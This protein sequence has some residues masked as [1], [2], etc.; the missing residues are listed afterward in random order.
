M[1]IVIAVVLL[2]ILAALG[3]AGLFMLRKPKPGQVGRGN[4]MARA[5]ALRVGLSV[6]LFLFIL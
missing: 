3:S 2:G 4:K 6:A 1:K 5:L